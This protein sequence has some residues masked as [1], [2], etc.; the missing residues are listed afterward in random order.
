MLNGVKVE[1]SADFKRLASE[2]PAGKA[3]S[4]LVQRQGNPIFLA[5]K[6]EE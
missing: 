2:L 3:V 1:S 4:I 5:L 6:A